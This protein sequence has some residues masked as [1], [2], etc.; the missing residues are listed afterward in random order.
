ML[1]IVY[2][3]V[4]TY[5]VVYDIQYV[6]SYTILYTTLYVF[7]IMSERLQ[8]SRTLSLEV[9]I[10]VCMCLN[11]FADLFQAQHT[12][13]CRRLYSENTCNTPPGHTPN[14][15]VDLCKDILVHGPPL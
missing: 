5:D 6:I 12:N 1:N 2:D 4:Y 3:I 7:L 15:N 11:I 8:I 10:A 13:L 14:D 9:S